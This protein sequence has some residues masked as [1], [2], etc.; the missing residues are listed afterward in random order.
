MLGHMRQNQV[1]RDRRDLIEP[2]LAEPA[3]DILFS[4]DAAAAIR[5]QAVIGGFSRGLGAGGLR[6]VGFRPV[7]LSG[8]RECGSKRPCLS[9][10]I[11]AAVERRRPTL[12]GTRCP[13]S[14]TGH[15]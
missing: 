4:G 10:L 6:H 3:L 13:T 1:R 2:R 5:P 12:S 8:I 7:R 14:A 9:D 15:H 11:A